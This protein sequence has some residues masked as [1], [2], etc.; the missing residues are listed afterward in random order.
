MAHVIILQ[1]VLAPR[2]N[3]EDTRG[4]L[5][6]EMPMHGRLIGEIQR[7]EDKT[8]TQGGADSVDL[9]IFQLTADLEATISWQLLPLNTRNAYGIT[10][11]VALAMLTQH[12]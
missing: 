12:G 5:I 11:R 6:G 8:N 4:N 9:P 1:E 7:S 3:P 10:A 2:C